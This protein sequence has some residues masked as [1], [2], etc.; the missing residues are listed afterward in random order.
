MEKKRSRMRTG[1]AQL[2]KGQLGIA[3]YTEVEWKKIKEAAAD[4][5]TFFDEYSE[6]LAQAQGEFESIQSQGL[7]PVKVPVRAAG[8]LAWCM[9][10]KISNDNYGRAAYAGYHLWEMDQ[11][12]HGKVGIC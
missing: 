11:P 1:T 7:K 2:P 6:W 10:Q 5:E 9:L 8:L 3:W 4:R 12:G